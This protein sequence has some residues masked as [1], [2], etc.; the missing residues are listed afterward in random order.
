M[1]TWEEE[2]KRRAV[3]QPLSAEERWELGRALVASLGDP[4]SA[5]K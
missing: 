4:V 1:Q 5:E 3:E 2:A